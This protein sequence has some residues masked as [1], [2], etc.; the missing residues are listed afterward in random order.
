MGTMIATGSDV[1]T[2]LKKQHVELTLLFAA[3]KAGQGKT[4][5]KAF[6]ALRRMLAVHETAEEELV[7]PV[8]RHVLPDGK[9]VISA[10][11]SEEKRAKTALAELEKLD[12]DSA[13][14]DQKF[15]SL[16]RAVIAHAESEER[17]EF[18][19][20]GNT[21]DQ[22]KLEK[23]RIAVEF[24]EKVAPTRPHAGVESQAANL[25]IG[26]FA[27]MVDRARDAISRKTSS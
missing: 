4:R 8:A 17:E 22:S 2:F 23:M 20:L 25:L 14:F 27:A 9:A 19:R 6:Y 18:E 26:P 1:V 11:L 24:A 21:L 15:E 13:E 7:H 16:E 3:V 12:I 10:R 5:A